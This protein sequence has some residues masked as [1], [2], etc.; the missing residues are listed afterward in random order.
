MHCKGQPV[1]GAD[2]AAEAFGEVLDQ[3]FVH[4][5]ATIVIALRCEKA[6]ETLG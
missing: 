4:G 2:L 1:D 6:S 5:G 3:D